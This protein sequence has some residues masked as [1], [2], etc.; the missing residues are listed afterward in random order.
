L[1]GDHEIPS[2]T[3]GR[4]VDRWGRI[5]PSTSVGSTR[6]HRLPVDAVAHG[7]PGRALVLGTDKA[8]RE[9]AL[10]PAHASSPWRELLP[11]GRS[12]GGPASAERGR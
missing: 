1:A 5:R 7:T 11:R 6:Q 12:L 4:S 10:T 2:T 9:V 8:V 3:I